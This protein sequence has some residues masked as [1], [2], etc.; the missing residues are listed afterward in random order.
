L[1]GPVRALLLLVALGAASCSREPVDKAP[2]PSPAATAAAVTLCEHGVPGNLCT[3]CTPALIAVFKAQGDWCAEHGVPESQCLQCHPDL[4]F[5]ASAATKDW[6]KEHAVAESKC[7]RCHPELIVRY[8]EAGDYCREHE[9]PASVCPRCH[10]ELVQAA[11]EQPP[12]FPEP[13]TRI[14]LASAETAREAGIETRRVERRRFARTVSS[15][16]TRIVMRSS[17]RW[18]TP[19]SSR[20]RSTSEMK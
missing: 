3:L 11:G 10:P 4:T 7:T 14:T 9:Y 20:S 13:G 6:C 8:I 2:P 5:T 19:W 18:T 1:Q 12:V 15:P 17:P 16:S